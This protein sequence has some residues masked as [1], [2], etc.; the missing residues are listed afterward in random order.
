M[1]RFLGLTHY[2]LLLFAF[3]F[4]VNIF[5]EELFQSRRFLFRHFKSLYRGIVF[6]KHYTSF[7][8]NKLVIGIGQR[9][10]DRRLTW[11][12]NFSAWSNLEFVHDLTE[13]CVYVAAD[14]TCLTAAL[15]KVFEYFDIEVLAEPDYV[16]FR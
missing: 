1:K 11:Y 6:Y 16:K 4:D 13:S 3:Y 2:L 5:C 10:V 12:V 7:K 9:H 8:S 15:S 14:Y